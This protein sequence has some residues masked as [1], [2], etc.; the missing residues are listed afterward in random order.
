VSGIT[1]LR[2]AALIAIGVLVAVASLVSFAESYRRS[3]L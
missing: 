2:K 1:R 3:G